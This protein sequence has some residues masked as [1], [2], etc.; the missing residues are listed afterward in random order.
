MAAGNWSASAPRASG[1][2]KSERQ[3][4]VD[5]PWEMFSSAVHA[6]LYRRLPSDACYRVTTA[7]GSYPRSAKS[8]ANFC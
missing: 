6:L 4:H 5:K 7:R 2:R 8:F 3:A 1:L